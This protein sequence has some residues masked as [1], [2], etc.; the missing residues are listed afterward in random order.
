MVRLGR[1]SSLLRAGFLA[2]RL[3]PLLLVAALVG[4]VFPQLGE[5]VGQLSLLWLGVLVFSVGLTLAPSEFLA[6]ARRPHLVALPVFLPWLTLLPAGIALAR[7][8][9]GAGSSGVLTIAAAPT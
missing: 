4:L 8:L 5:S 1:T 9:P 2:D 3:I 7:F 6:A